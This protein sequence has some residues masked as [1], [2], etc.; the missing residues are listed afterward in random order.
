M[1]TTT[2]IFRKVAQKLRNPL[3]TSSASSFW[4][5]VLK[6]DRHSAEQ[7]LSSH[8][9]D[10]DKSIVV[11]VRVIAIICVSPLPLSPRYLATPMIFVFAIRAPCAASSA[12]AARSCQSVS[13]EIRSLNFRK[14]KI[15]YWYCPSNTWYEI[16]RKPLRLSTP[17]PPRNWFPLSKFT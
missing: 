16:S 5:Q 4:K 7:G 3:E 6:Y 9:P 13:R 8:A 10:S 15:V 2:W 12:N 14:G 1:H 17:L 11:P